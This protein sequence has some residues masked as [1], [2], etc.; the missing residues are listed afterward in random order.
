M[1]EVMI[2]NPGVEKVRGRYAAL[3]SGDVSA[4]TGV[5]DDAS[6]L[7]VPGRSGLAGEYQGREAILAVLGRMAE[8]T[9]NTLRLGSSRLV[10][11][12]DH[13]LVLQGH[14][15]AAAATTQLDT[16]IIHTL[17]LRDDR[18]REAW[19]FSL[20]QDDFDEFWSGR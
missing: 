5:L 7:H 10:V 9:H 19:F 15:S 13:V 18:I 8:Y 20:N 3:L 12:D 2:S 14:I 16:D 17:S 6:I 1:T 4:A 11:E